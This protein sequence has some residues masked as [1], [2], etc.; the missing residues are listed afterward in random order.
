MTKLVFA[1]LLSSLFF[2]YSWALQAPM[3]QEIPYYGEEFYANGPFSAN[4]QQ[5]KD[6]LKKILRSKHLKTQGGLD[7][8]V[9]SC[10]GPNCYG[11][12]AVG[13]NK[14]RVFMF[15]NYYLVNQNGGY[16][17][18]DVYCQKVF[19]ANEFSSRKPGPNQIPNDTVVNAEHTW[20]QS[21]FSNRYD[22]E[23]QKSDVHH[24][25]PTDSKMNGIRGN[26]A[27]G[28]VAQDAN[29]KL[30][31]TKGGARF[32]QS[33]SGD[34]PVF[35]PPTTHRGNVARSLFYFS[36]KYDLPIDAHQEAYLRKWN[37]EDPVDAEEAD[38][39]EKIFAL[40]GSRNPF[41]DYPELA[42][43]IQDF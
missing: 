28:E 29:T 14:A 7:Q 1:A 19:G 12:V 26:Y 32:G 35:E 2:S 37:K 21:K 16:G 41:V 18:R 10:G 22:K 5:L 40:Q 31:C 25:Y 11:H 6:L 20:P 9:S 13:Y 23:M 38:R 36:I 15:G 33:T 43:R 42:D 27:F 3:S 17:V 24:L 34:N 39:N 4:D 8:I 30:P